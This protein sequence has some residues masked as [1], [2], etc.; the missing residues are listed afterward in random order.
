MVG[1]FQGVQVFALEKSSQKEKH[2]TWLASRYHLFHDCS[3]GEYKYR[4]IFAAI[5]H[6]KYG[7]DVLFNIRS[8]T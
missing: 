1:R 6:N 2:D 3:N 7:E 5:R 8:L 4:S